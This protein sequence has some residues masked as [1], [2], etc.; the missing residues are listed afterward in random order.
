MQSSIHAEELSK[1]EHFLEPTN[2]DTTTS[3]NHKTSATFREDKNEMSS[4][5]KELDKILHKVQ[6][7]ALSECGITS[8]SENEQ[9]GPYFCLESQW[10]DNIVSLTINMMNLQY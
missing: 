2:L 7:T 6:S 4:K 9:S 10:K 1:K 3:D 5:V 8:G